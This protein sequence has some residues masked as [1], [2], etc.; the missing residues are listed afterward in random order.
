MIIE[1]DLINSLF[2]GFAGLMVLNH[3]RVLHAEKMVRGV[4]VVSSF[5]FTVWGVWNVYY[6][7]ALNQPLSFYGGLF[8][9]VANA[10]YVWMMIFY[11]KK[12]MNF[13]S[14]SLLLQGST[15]GNGND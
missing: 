2:E 8:V 7:P 5:F 6:Y 1:P 4:S 13:S 15:G 3:C 11:R 10:V 14:S 12:G 9:V